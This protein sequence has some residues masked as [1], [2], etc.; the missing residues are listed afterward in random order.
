MLLQGSMDI[1]K[2][3]LHYEDHLTY[4]RKIIMQVT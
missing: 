1:L 4:L 2:C 3:R